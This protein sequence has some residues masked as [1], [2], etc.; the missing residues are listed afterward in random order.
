MRQRR[1]KVE[2]DVFGYEVVGFLIH[3]ELI[4]HAPCEIN[5][6]YDAVQ[7]KQLKWFINKYKVSFPRN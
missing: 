7:Q 2:L 4:G 6:L 1:V 5:M 3:L